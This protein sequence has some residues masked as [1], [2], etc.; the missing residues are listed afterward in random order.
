MLTWRAQEP[1]LANTPDIE[2]EE[3]PI[4]CRG[5]VQDMPDDSV[6]RTRVQTESLVQ[7]EQELSAS[8]SQPSSAQSD[9]DRQAHALLNLIFQIHA[10]EL[11]LQHFLKSAAA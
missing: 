10:L 8:A 6:A 5:P 3:G 2:T 7:H 1:D 11:P 4:L 9:A